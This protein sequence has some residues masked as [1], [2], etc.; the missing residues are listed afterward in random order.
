MAEVT[1]GELKAQADLDEVGYFDL[2]APPELAFPTDK[3]VI[4]S[5]KNRG[6]SAINKIGNKKRQFGTASFD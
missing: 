4:D 1:G 3:L 5:L 6:I 2:A